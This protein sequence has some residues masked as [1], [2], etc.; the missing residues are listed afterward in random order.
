MFVLLLAAFG[1][2][3][4]YDL[5]GTGAFGGGSVQVTEDFE[6]RYHRLQEQL[7]LFPDRRVLDYWEQVNRLNLL[8]NKDP[9]S[10]GAQVD[11]VLF[12]GNRYFLDGEEVFER[13]LY[14]PGFTSPSPNF[15]LRLE[16]SW[17]RRKGD[18]L[19]ITLGDAYAS[20]GRGAALNMVK[21]TNIDIDTS[22][23]GA[24]LDARAGDVEAV[25]IT[26]VSNTQD[27][28]RFNPNF[29]ITKDE[30]HMVTGLRLDHY[31]V[32]PVHMGAHGTLFRFARPDGFGLPGLARYD[33]PLDALTGGLTAEGS[34]KGVDYFFEGDVFQYRSPE[35]TGTGE[36]RSLGHLLYGS[37][38]FYPGKMSI[39]VEGKH[40]QD[41]ERIN[42]FTVAEGWEVA[43]TP[44]LEYEMVITEDSAAAV[45]SNDLW[46]GRIRAD[47]AIKPGTF[48]PYLSVA[49]FRDEDL[50]GLHFNP[51][52]ETIG[53]AVGG[54]QLL[55]GRRIIQFNGGYRIDQRDVAADGA[56]RM[57]HLDA[58]IQIPVTEA[59]AV[60]I[61]LNGRR[62]WWGENAFE[63]ADF[64]EMNNALG[65]HQ[66][67]RWIFLIYQD[68]TDNPL[69][70]SRGNLDDHLY[71]ALEAIWR[72]QPSTT[73]RFF[74]G[75]YKAGIRCSG[76]Q[77]R[78]LPGFEGGRVSW[79]TTF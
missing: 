37:A 36:D 31:A 41:T 49:A 75:A 2:A 1:P 20:F 54:L 43:A 74:Y 17:V 70:Q 28:S 47:Y 79:S 63:Q 9:L 34:L 27:I 60:E 67:E 12:V 68:F 14:E 78:S 53:H 40:S 5:V 26:G 33:E 15:L 4:A 61:A 52:P 45:N 76:G 55:E 13:N 73:V 24:R 30:P 57:A 16:K 71:G 22:I 66:G 59:G 18:N 35:M 77:C 21:N 6:L 64:L 32:G 65:W 51:S 23:R 48:V 46:G 19:D 7:P 10:I 38:A 25:L 8:V 44:T 50:G 56:D 11:E 62:F 69:I 42:A 3:H 29:G 58:E 72:P 39:L